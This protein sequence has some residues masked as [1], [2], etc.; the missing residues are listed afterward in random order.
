MLRSGLLAMD[1][2][3]LQVNVIWREEEARQMVQM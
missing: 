1:M 3:S 2:A